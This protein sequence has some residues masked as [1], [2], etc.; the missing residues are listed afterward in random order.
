VSGTVIRCRFLFAF[1]SRAEAK[2]VQPGDQLVPVSP[3]VDVSFQERTRR[4]IW[5]IAHI[6]D[7]RASA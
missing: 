6:S 4:R 2:D 7:R 5:I 3:F 1:P